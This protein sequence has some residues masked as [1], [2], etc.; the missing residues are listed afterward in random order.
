MKKIARFLGNRIVVIVMFILYFGYG[1]VIF[2]PETPVGEAVLEGMP[3]NAEVLDLRSNYTIEEVSLFFS[4]LGEKGMQ[5][6]KRNLL[7]FDMLYPFIAMLFFAG[8]HIWAF[9][10]I[11]KRYVL[12]AGTTSA[13]LYFSLDVLENS[14]IV[15]QLGCYPSLSNV[16]IDTSSNITGLKWMA[17][18]TNLFLGA[19]TVI[20]VLVLGIKGYVKSKKDYQ[21]TT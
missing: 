4:Q 17:V 10:N 19:V 3:P 7:S 1:A 20:W 13:I 16:A 8:L 15:S 12:I 21:H 5:T 11:K 6:Y 2:N 14:L 9:K 18:N